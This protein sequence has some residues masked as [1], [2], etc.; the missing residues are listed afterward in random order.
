MFSRWLSSGILRAALF[1][2]VGTSETSADFWDTTRRNIPEDVNFHTC[3]RKNLKSHLRV[4]NKVVSVAADDACNVT[5]GD[6][7][8][9][10]LFTKPSVIPLYRFF[11][12]LVK[13]H[14]VLTVVWVAWKMYGKLPQ[15]CFFA[16]HASNKKYW[17]LFLEET[18]SVYDDLL[19]YSS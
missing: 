13:K 18:G 1:E 2:V 11:A 4:P 9:T 8:L 14:C 7:K 5:G 12:L 19:L 17:Q 3:R 6:S 15:Q 16:L 10:T